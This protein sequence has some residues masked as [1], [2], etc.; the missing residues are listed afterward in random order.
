VTVGE[1]RMEHVLLAVAG[2][3]GMAVVPESVS[4]RCVMPGLRFVPL[5][6]GEGVIRKAVLT[7]PDADS[8]A[9]AAFLRALAQAWRPRAAGERIA[10]V[11]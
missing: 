8:L 5:E 6:G 7:R 4:E 9:T 1:A 10:A 11:A 3:R 2:G